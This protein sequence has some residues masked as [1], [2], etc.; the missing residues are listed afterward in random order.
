M[1]FRRRQCYRRSGSILRSA[2]PRRK[3]PHGSRVTGRTYFSPM[4]QQTA[5][6]LLAGQ[7]KSPVVWLLAAAAALAAS[8][9]EWTESAAILLVLLV[10]TLIGFF[11]ELRAVRSMEALRTLGN[12]SSR[13]RRDGKLKTV[14]AELVVPGDIVLLE[15][16]DVVTADI[17][18]VEARNLSCDESTLT[19][20]SGAGG[21][22]RCSGPACRHRRRPDLDAAQGHRHHARH[23]R[24][25]GGGDRHGHR[26]RSDHAARDRGRKRHLPARAQARRS[27]PPTGRR[28]PR[29]YRS[30]RRRRHGLW[31]RSHAHDRGCASR[32]PSPPSRKACQSSQPWRLPAACGAW[33]GG[34]W[35]SNA[36][37]RSKR[38][39]PPPWSAPTRPARSRKIA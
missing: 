24:G 27:D 4:R 25:S 23:G 37:P 12:R 16:G 6:S 30:D 22:K 7:L 31:P 35:W 17:R 34:T 10:N 9:S 13:V 39:A 26:A 19:G 8:F 38:S 15:S 2:S 36:W 20:E 11:T 18:L 29:Y 14:P 3:P 21:E 32:L 1:P 28:D 5:L 33:R